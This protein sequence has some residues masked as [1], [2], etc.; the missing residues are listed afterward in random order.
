MERSL[1]YVLEQFNITSRVLPFGNGHINDTY[2]TEDSQFILQRINTSVFTDPAAVMENI[3]RVTAH[4]KK[5]ITA[6]GGD[7]DRET[8]TVIPARNGENCFRLDRDHVYRVYRLIPETKTIQQEKTP[9]L[10]YQAGIGYGRFQQ[11]LRDFPA[12]QLHETIHDFHHM[13]KRVEALKEAASRDCCGRLRFAREEVS[14]ALSQASWAGTVTNGLETGE[15]P[16]RVTHND[17]KIDNILFDIQTDRPIC[18]IDLDTVMPGSML[19]DFGDA[20]RL[21]AS[22]AA[23]D[24]TDLTKVSFHPELY[25]SFAEGYLQ[26]AGTML[27]DRELALLPFSVRLMAYETGV[28]FL[29]DYLNGDTYYKIHHEGHNLE[30]A[31]N[32]LRLTADIMEKEKAGLL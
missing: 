16:L 12:D 30:R 23:E 20:L 6:C 5:K 1:Q 7:P 24:E 11:M 9:A 18:V 29:T 19:Y 17:T 2:R 15:L 22:A 21:G 13:P 27:T 28:R 25:H 31:R 4:L 3:S 26:E 14:Y 8:L 32:Q 10:L